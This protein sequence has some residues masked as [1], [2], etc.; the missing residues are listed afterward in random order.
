M[1]VNQNDRK[2]RPFMDSTP[3]PLGLRNVVVLAAALHHE[4]ASG[5]NFD[6]THGA[7]PAVAAGE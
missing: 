7:G 6:A 1:P 5:I 4:F 3:S 2:D